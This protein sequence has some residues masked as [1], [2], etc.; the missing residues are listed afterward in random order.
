MNE[1]MNEWNLMTCI[2]SGWPIILVRDIEY[3][4]TACVWKN[5]H[6]QKGKR[7][8]QAR[9]GA[10]L[11]IK[12][13]Q[14]TPLFYIYGSHYKSWMAWIEMGFI[15]HHF[16]IFLY[17]NEQY[18]GLAGINV[19]LWYI[20]SFWPMDPWF[21]PN[22]VSNSKF[23]LNYWCVLLH[24]PCDCNLHSLYPLVSKAYTLDIQF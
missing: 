7:S 18:L 10:P 9:G 21:G 15:L 4:Y 20:S 12:V 16:N 14:W 8:G 11:Q 22:M 6:I 3:I 24:G 17:R 19:G 2:W 1:W 13:E 5:I 23:C